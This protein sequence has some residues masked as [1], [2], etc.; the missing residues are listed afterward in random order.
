MAG[1]KKAAG[2][3]TRATRAERGPSPKR[4]TIAPEQRLYI[5]VKKGEKVLAEYIAGAD[6]GGAVRTVEAPEADAPVAEPS[7][8]SGT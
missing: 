1:K 2:T 4:I 5:T 7:P 8:V 3:R 6:K